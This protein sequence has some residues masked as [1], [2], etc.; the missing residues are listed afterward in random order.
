MVFA[1]Q[2][3]HTAGSHIKNLNLEKNKKNPP[4]SLRLWDR[5]ITRIWSLPLAPTSGRL[6]I[7]VTTCPPLS[8]GLPNHYKN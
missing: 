3:N 5:D 8:S 2:K 1:F 7:L 6:L 4:S